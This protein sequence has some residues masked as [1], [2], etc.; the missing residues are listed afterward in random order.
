MVKMAYVVM[1]YPRMMGAGVRWDFEGIL[2]IVHKTNEIMQNGLGPESLDVGEVIKDEEILSRSV[3]KKYI[4]HYPTTPQKKFQVTKLF[5]SASGKHNATFVYGDV[6]EVIFENLSLDEVLKRVRNV[7]DLDTHF[8]REFFWETTTGGKLFKFYLGSKFLDEKKLSLPLLSPI[9]TVFFI[10]IVVD[11]SEEVDEISK[12]I[13]SLGLGLR[14]KIH[15][16]VWIGQ[17]PATNFISSPFFT[18]AINPIILLPPKKP[19]YKYNDF[20]NGLFNSI[21]AIGEFYN[22]LEI[23]DDAHEFCA[24]ASY[25]VPLELSQSIGS[26]KINPLK[27]IRDIYG[28]RS[29]K[30][31]ERLFHSFLFEDIKHLRFYGSEAAEII[32]RQEGVFHFQVIAELLTLIHS[33]SRYATDIIYEN[34]QSQGKD[35]DEEF[36][37]ALF[38]LFETRL[39]SIK[40][41]LEKFVSDLQGVIDAART[42]V[43]LNLAIV[44]LI[45]TLL[46]TVAFAIFPIQEWLK[47]IFHILQSLLINRSR[48]CVL[49][50][51]CMYLPWRPCMRL[52]ASAACKPSCRGC[53]LAALSSQS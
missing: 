11:T 18:I 47:A 51:F 49:P 29:F 48:D 24:L 50:I 52:S 26:L 3:I 4:R 10:V 28:L 53:I 21:I 32:K 12:T 22:I 34:F 45:W 19:N 36:R 20:L 23:I 46:V 17:S 35:L 16:H 38:N 6:L 2:N 43:Q 37:A 44:T 40:D 8:E 7:E 5:Q 1:P 13:Q 30:K 25:S 15:G 42:S 41:T 9:L 27:N 39:K 33:Y 14:E 31:Y